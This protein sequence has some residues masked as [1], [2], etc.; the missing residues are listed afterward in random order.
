MVFVLLLGVITVTIILYMKQ[1]AKTMTI[2]E[3]EAMPHIDVTLDMLNIAI[4]NSPD[5]K[6]HVQMQGHKLN[7][8]L[9]T[10]NEENNK[11]VIKEQQRKK[12]LQE[13]I[14]FHATPTIIVQLPKSESK[15]L[16]FNGADGDFTIQDLAFDTVQLKTSAGIVYLK[17][18]SASNAEI[19]SKDGNVT[20][21]NSAID[22]LGITS[23]AGD[24][25]IKESVGSAHT[26]QTADGQIKLTEAI[27]QP[28]VHVESLSGDIGIYY[29]KAPT[30]L[31]L[32]TARKDIEIT[33]PNYDKKAHMIG[34]GA[35]LLSA[36]TKDGV[37][38]IK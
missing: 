12:N 9:L 2:G 38:V 37:I 8:H 25:A 16:T 5:D 34:D 32:M 28:N 4:S 15:T 22:H 3:F 23:T 20:I 14:Q 10:I 11:F 24:V 35:N 33:L 1:P 29:K 13:N 26:I 30:S 36:E 6:I 19:Q 7:K 18:L 17:S 31:R 21:A 27:E